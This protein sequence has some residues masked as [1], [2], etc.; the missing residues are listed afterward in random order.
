[1]QYS[2]SVIARYTSPEALAMIRRI[3]EFESVMIQL[4]GIT[5]LSVSACG[6]IVRNTCKETEYSWREV[7]ARLKWDVMKKGKTLGQ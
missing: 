4:S 6:D 5:G 7:A 2:M 1:M 3:A